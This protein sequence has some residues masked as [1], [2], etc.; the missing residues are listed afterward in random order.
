MSESFKVIDGKLEI[1]NTPAS[2]IETLD[3]D[4][5]V[6]NRAGAQ[7]KVDHLQIDLDEAKAEVAKWDARIAAIDK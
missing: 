2:A 4:E 6:G 3:R 7:T 5:V 1:T